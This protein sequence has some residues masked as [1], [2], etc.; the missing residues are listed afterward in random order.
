M[1]LATMLKELFF[2]IVAYLKIHFHWVIWFLGGLVFVIHLV[3]S[4]MQVGEYLSDAADNE[5]MERAEIEFAI[6]LCPAL[7]PAG[8]GEEI[9]PLDQGPKSRLGM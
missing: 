3:A 4:L 8:G 6:H 5:V 7:A 1:A 2:K 9:P